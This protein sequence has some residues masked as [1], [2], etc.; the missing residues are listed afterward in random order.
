MLTCIH[1]VQLCGLPAVS[2][3]CVLYGMLAML[4]GQE[5]GHEVT[6]GRSFLVDTVAT[7]LLRLT[8]SGASD[9]NAKLIGSRALVLWT[10]KAWYGYVRSGRTVM[11]IWF[12]PSVLLRL[13]IEAYVKKIC[14]ITQV[15]M[16]KAH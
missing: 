16:W 6:K 14:V 11:Q 3:L 13:C 12:I 7:E 4:D 9:T 5:L 1:R 15:F 10:N 8:A 2:A